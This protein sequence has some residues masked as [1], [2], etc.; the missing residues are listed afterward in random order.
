MSE[1]TIYAYEF[2]CD[3][4]GAQSGPCRTLPAGWFVTTLDLNGCGA[5]SYT[6]HTCPT[7]AKPA[8]L[9]AAEGA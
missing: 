6:R 2:R 4:C 5:P 3:T 1:T 7:C 9:A 8:A